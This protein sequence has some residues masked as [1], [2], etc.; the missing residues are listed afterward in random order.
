VRRL[1]LRNS[2]LAAPLLSAAL[3]HPPSAHASTFTTLYQFQGGTTGAEP[4]SGVVQDN[5][6]IL[7]GETQEAGTTDCVTRFTNPDLGC[8]TLYSFSRTAGLKTLVLFNGANGAV[9]QNR[10]LLIGST[11]YGTTGAG[12]VNDKGV[13]FSVKTDG[14]GFKL[15][16]EFNGT[17]GNQPF[18]SLAADRSG[19]IYGVTI[20]GG[21]SYPRPGYGVLYRIA[22]DGSFTILHNFA[23]GADGASPTSIIVEKSGTVIGGATTG[24]YKKGSCVFVGCGTVYQYTPSTASFTVLHTFNGEDGASPVLGGI[25]RNGAIYGN[26]GYFF[27]LS[28]TGSYKL[29]VVTS[30]GDQAGYYNGI[31]PALTPGPSLTSVSPEDIYG[32]NGTLFQQVGSALTVLHYFQGPEG[33]GSEATPLIGPAGSFIGTSAVGGGACNCGTIWHYMP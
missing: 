27:T 23:N 29:L 5:A 24:G 20:V 4:K 10:P 28:Q 9:G 3:L 13:V 32:G 7:Y 30:G 8:G 16:H 11:L 15:L 1:I 19:N 21:S 17:D 22:A 14:T 26:V 2:L 6:G 25:A 18:G 12:G 33:T 31:A